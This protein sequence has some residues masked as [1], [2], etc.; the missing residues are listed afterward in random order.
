MPP[1]HVAPSPTGVK[2]PDTVMAGGARRLAVA[3]AL[4]SAHGLPMASARV[5]GV[6][7]NGAWSNVQCYW[8][9]GAG[10]PMLHARVS[11]AARAAVGDDHEIVLVNDGPVT[12]WL[13]TATFGN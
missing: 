5:G 7:V 12:L 11:A 10:L 6:Q 3:R 8:R 4:P 2:V 9:E 1:R 13:D